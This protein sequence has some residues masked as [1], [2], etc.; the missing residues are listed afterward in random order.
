MGTFTSTWSTPTLTATFPSTQTFST[1]TVTGFTGTISAYTFSG[2]VSGGQY[3]ILLLAS[4]GAITIT[5]LSGGGTTAINFNFSS[6]IS[7]TSGKYAVMTV[8]YASSKYFVSC[9]AFNS[10]N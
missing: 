10:S 3:V 1:A 5:P 8:V 2:G 9:S 6:N 7:V 4:G